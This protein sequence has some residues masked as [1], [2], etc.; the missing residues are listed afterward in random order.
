M[1]IASVFAIAKTLCQ[2][3]YM[4]TE[5]GKKMWSTYTT[6]YFSAIR[7]ISMYDKIH[8]KKEKKKKIK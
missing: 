2:L 8:K 1:I 4:L 5:I 3:K 6:E 7:F